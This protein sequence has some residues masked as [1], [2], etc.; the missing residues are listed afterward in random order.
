MVFEAQGTIYVGLTVRP[1]SKK[2]AVETLPMTMIRH[3]FI[4]RRFDSSLPALAI[5]LALVPSGCGYQVIGSRADRLPAITVQTVLNHSTDIHAVSIAQ[6]ALTSRLVHD[7][8][9]DVRLRVVIHPA[10]RAQV[11]YGRDGFAS[12]ETTRATVDLTLSA[13]GT[14]EWKSGLE[15]GVSTFTHGQSLLQTRLAREGSF[16]RA[17]R[18]AIFQAL[19]RAEAYWSR[20]KES[21]RP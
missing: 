18:A 12:L 7:P 6:Q 13:P 20:M 4:M 5:I 10:N 19:L 11:A 9:S 14:W 1:P 16:R 3:L 17:L 15:T 21:D 8:K 2:L